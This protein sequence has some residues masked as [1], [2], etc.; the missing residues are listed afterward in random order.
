MLAAKNFQIDR[1]EFQEMDRE[2]CGRS[3]SNFIKRAWPIVEPGIQYKSG[4]AIDAMCEHLEAVTYGQLIRLLI[5]VPP[6]MMKSL[7]ANVFWPCWE[8]GPKGLSNYR[9]INAAHEVELAIRDVRKAR[10]IIESDWYQDLWPTPFARD[11]NEKKYFENE[12]KGFRQA[13]AAKS[14]TGK[15]GHRLLYDDPHS[16]EGALSDADRP[17]TIRVFRETATSRMIDAQ[18]SAIV[19]IMQRI[20]TGDVSG[21]ILEDMADEYEHL[22]LPME[23]E[24]DRRCVT[25]LGF[26]DPRKEEGE[27]VFPERFPPK[28]VARDKKAMGALA[29]AGQFQQRPAPRSGGFFEWQNMEIVSAIPAGMTEFVRYW[30]KA[31]TEDG[32]CYT[33]GVL[34]G[35]HTGV[36]YVI[37]VQRER[38]KPS[39]REK[40]IRQTAE[41]DE[42]LLKE[43]TGKEQKV[44]YFV[45]QEPGSAGKEST[46]GT[47]QRMAGYIIKGDRP[48]G[49]KETR[50]APYSAQIEGGNVKVLKGKWTKDFRDEHQNYPVGYKDQIDAASGAFN[51]LAIKKKKAPGAR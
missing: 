50:A 23:F 16:I 42:E 12:N 10:M 43:L 41:L 18:T 13:C 22:C 31:G 25:S 21:V 37:D 11:Q 51:K 24:K 34:M 8:W 49:D 33:A 7:L 6:G 14:L 1:A 28:E 36:Y 5:N 26:V 17:K 9:Y 20:H 45:E 48:T 32:G 3:L 29:V 40:L 15:R 35:K 27:L 46:E 30:D 38:F 19:V 4:W 2:F 39:K 47:I 44:K